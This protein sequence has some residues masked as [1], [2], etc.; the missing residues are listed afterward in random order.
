MGVSS[1]TLSSSQSRGLRFRQKSKEGP[2]PS[3]P[4][5]SL[6]AERPA[7]QALIGREL[8]RRGSRENT[9]RVWAGLDGT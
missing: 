5:A 3:N 9:R 2:A 7:R 1:S 4:P 6:L 8:A